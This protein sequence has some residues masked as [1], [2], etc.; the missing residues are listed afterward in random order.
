MAIAGKQAPEAGGNCSACERTYNEYPKLRKGF[1]AFKEGGT[2]GAGGIDGSAGVV[3]A[4]EVDENEGKAYG[5]SGKVVGR[6]VCL[7]RSTEHHKYEDE[8]E[9]HFCH[10]SVHDVVRSA[11][12]GSSVSALCKRWICAYEH[13]KEC[14]G[15]NGTDDL[16][17]DVACAVFSAH[18][19]GKEHAKAD[20]GI[21]VAT[22][23]AA[24]GVG[25]SYNGK[26]EGKGCAYH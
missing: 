25:H 8:R 24:N 14:C 13:G 4:N 10:E 3:D 9:E 23:N 16:C 2:D 21:D 7:A 26:A 18:P 6:S 1:A 11:G 12:I 22:G 19:A 20:G 17:H 15:N 5:Q